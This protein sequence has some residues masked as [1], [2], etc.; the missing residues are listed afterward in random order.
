MFERAEKKRGTIEFLLSTDDSKK[1][2]LHLQFDDAYLVNFYQYFNN[3]NSLLVRTK[4][5]LSAKT[6][7]FGNGKA[8]FINDWKI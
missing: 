8:T 2:Y 6:M 5:T 7:R 4:V 1:K 3:N